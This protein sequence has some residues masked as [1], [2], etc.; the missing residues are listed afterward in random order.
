MDRT[1][2]CFGVDSILLNAIDNS[3]EFEYGVF[4]PCGSTFDWCSTPSPVPDPI[5]PCANQTQTDLCIPIDL[6]PDYA[7]LNVRGSASHCYQESESHM[8]NGASDP[9]GVPCA[10]APLV[11]TPKCSQVPD[12]DDLDKQQFGV[13][14]MVEYDNGA[15]SW[16]AVGNEHGTEFAAIYYADKDCKILAPFRPTTFQPTIERRDTPSCEMW[17]KVNQE[18]RISPDVD[19]CAEA[20]NST[21]YWTGAVQVRQRWWDVEIPTASDPDD[22]PECVDANAGWWC[23]DVV[24]RGQ[25]AESSIH[26]LKSC[27]CCGN[28]SNCGFDDNR[29][30]EEVAVSLGLNIFAEA[31]K[32]FQ[33][34]WRGTAFAPTDEAFKALMGPDPTYCFTSGSFN[35]YWFDLVRTHTTRLFLPSSTLI[36]GFSFA[37]E[38]FR[39]PDGWWGGLEV[40]NNGTSITLTPDDVQP[41]TLPRVITTA[42]VKASHAV[43]HVID[44]VFFDWVPHQCVLTFV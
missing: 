13:C 9:W 10:A 15:R 40:S 21:P 33:P 35:W 41:K 38:V 28:Q 14:I 20:Q 1:C 17:A 6:P 44:G 24:K 22:P 18:R 42:D 2:Q 27:G 39:D 29:S 32:L 30:L 36:D 34:G 4:D 8:C 37:N 23:D 26:C 19:S 16:T 5:L 12:H 43:L 25:C 31:L 11:G 7:V 3:S